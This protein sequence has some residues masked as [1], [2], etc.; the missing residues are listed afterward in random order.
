MK[1]MLWAKPRGRKAT[2]NH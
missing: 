1:T 2:H